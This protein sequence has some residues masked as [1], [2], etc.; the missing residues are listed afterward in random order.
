MGGEEH[1]APEAHPRSDE[2]TT[3]A[4]A[5]RLFEASL[6][7]VAIVGLD[8]L[9]HRV[10][11]AWGRTL[12]WDPDELVG[13]AYLDLMHPD[14]RVGAMGHVDRL[15]SGEVDEVELFEVRLR[16]V[17]GSYRSFLGSAFIDRASGLLMAVGKDITER[18]E[19]EEDL[20]EAEQRFRQAFE[21]APVGMALATFD[22]DL[23]RV[24]RALCDI[25]GYAEHE[26]IGLERSALLHPDDDHV[27][28]A[29][30]RRVLDRQTATAHSAEQ[31][32]QH[33]D[34]HLV[35]VDT[36]ISLVTDADD[37]PLYLVLQVA[38][39]TERRRAEEA[40]AAANRQLA[41]RNEELEVSNDHL[42]RFAYVASHDLKSPLQVVR[43]FLDLLVRTNADRLDDQ[44]RT[45]VDAALRGAERMENLI[46][47]LLSYASVGRGPTSLTVID[48]SEVV[49]EVRA[50]LA[51][52]MNEAGA[53]LTVGN[54][55]TV[56]GDRTQLRQI[57]QNLVTNAVKFARPGVAPEV[58]IAAAV[59][60]GTCVLSV[61]DNGIGVPKDEREQIFNM[62]TR[63][64]TGDEYPGTG[65]GLAICQRV[66]ENHGG[67]IWVEDSEGGGSRF[68]FTLSG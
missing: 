48:L 25:T 47:D 44:G 39:V 35:W 53:V 57:F 12:G 63:L 20:R 65:I 29:A 18:T 24:N 10:N 9:F 4:V 50:D 58:T 17:D 5:S 38:D 45:F 62:F 8:G 23:L 26:L 19:T 67:S 68:R 28:L 52:R 46:D 7:L 6:D 51:E 13:T 37:R 16:V 42:E 30:A 34:G 36:S 60:D 64:H 31:R 61:E 56:T 15:S 54:L 41:R 22:G 3:A 55:P 21:N 1:S 14:D 40:L 59:E 66:V 49:D 43:G 11:P 33:A 27:F 32:F 2:A